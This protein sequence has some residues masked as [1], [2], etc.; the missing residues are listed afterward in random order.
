MSLLNW[1]RHGSSVVACEKP[2]RY[3]AAAARRAPARRQTQRWPPPA[4]EAR[5]DAAAHDVPCQRLPVWLPVVRAAGRLAPATAGR[6]RRAAH[7]APQRASSVRHCAPAAA[8]PATMITPLS[9]SWTLLSML[10]SWRMLPRKP[11]ISTP[12]SVPA[13]APLAAHQAGAADHH[14]GDRVELEPV[15]GVRLALQVL[16]HVEHAGQAREHARERVDRDLHPV[17]GDAREPRRLL[18]AADGVDVAAEGRA[19]EQRQRRS[20]SAARKNRPGHRQ[21]AP[22]QRPQQ[23]E[24]CGGV[25][26]GVDRHAP[27]G[28]A[29]PPAVPRRGRPPSSPA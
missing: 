3:F 22:Q 14:G 1:T 9:T 15:A 23:L 21:D 11:K 6:R 7:A 19:C 24:V 4:V 28:P 27:T 10:L 12:T 16:R 2:I 8:P 17:D 29:R 18:V 5:S 25:G 20:R 13:D 26:A